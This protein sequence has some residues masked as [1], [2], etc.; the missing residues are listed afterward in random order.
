MTNNSLPPLPDLAPIWQSL[1]EHAEEIKKQ[2]LRDMFAADPHRFDDFS[3][4][5]GEILLDYSKNR[6]TGKTFELLEELATRAGLKSWIERM[7]KGE[8]I[9]NTENRAVLHTALRAPADARV[10]V[11]GR[12]VIPDVQRVLERME[13]FCSKVHDGSW[14]G[15]SSRAITDIVNI[16]IGG[17]DLG[18]H[19]VSTALRPYWKS[20]LTAHFVSNVDGTD[21]NETLVKLDPE[22]TLFIIA[23]KT[24]T[25]RETMTNAHTARQWFLDNSDNDHNHVRR[26]FVAVSTNSS[27]VQAFG[28]DQENMFEFWDWVGG[29]YSLWS[30]IGL[31]IALIV[32]M[33]NFRRLLAG[34]H[35]MDEHFR[36]ADF[37]G[38]MPVIL[39]LLGIWYRNFLG[40]SN[41]AILPYDHSLRLLPAYL[42]QADME[43]NG[44]GV[45]REGKP[46]D[47]DTGPIIWGQPGTNGQHAFFQLIHQGTELV[48]ADFILPARTHHPISEHHEILSA[49]C[50]AQT[51]AL[52]RGKT[53]AE[54]RQELAREGMPEALIETLAPHKVFPGNKPTNTIVIRQLT[55]YN[56]G[57]LIAL[58]EH[59]IFV[60]SI[61]WNINAFDQWGVELGKQLAD[62]IEA[63][64]DSAHECSSHD[65]STNGLVNHLKSQ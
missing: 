33:D 64:L 60:E 13:A 55:P 46:V 16:G 19:M 25:T 6:I 24:F 26:H 63:E 9:N 39:G 31:P 41:H 32:G 61:I 2:H 30:A 3:L 35:E 37:L 28:I 7:F 57:K 43:S 1:Q 65:S 54:V 15:Y 53:E 18:P 59:K 52:M 34:A 58:Y 47:Y 23:S 17:S 5:L 40:A 42:Q 8:R 27:A 10:I 21:I 12:N 62:I 4:S 14:T 45:N 51:E 38:N 29:R 20:G 36:N 56:L 49:N 44:K 48:P 22:T 50:I 11:D